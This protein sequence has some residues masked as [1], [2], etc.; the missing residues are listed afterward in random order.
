MPERFTLNNKTYDIPDDKIGIFMSK[1]PNAVKTK[2]K[3][4]FDDLAAKSTEFM[5][6]VPLA[7]PPT[8][9]AGGLVQAIGDALGQKAQEKI[10]DTLPAGTRGEG[11]RQGLGIAGRILFDPTSFI[12]LGAG[13]KAGGKLAKEIPNIIG[14]IFKTKSAAGFL[15]RSS[16]KKV[17]N[18]LAKLHELNK[19]TPLSGEYGMAIDAIKQASGKAKATHAGVLEEVARAGQQPF[20]VASKVEDPI[21]GIKQIRSGRPGQVHG[22]LFSPEEIAKKGF[23]W[24]KVENG[25]I[26]ESGRW[27][28][29]EEAA[30]RLGRTGKLDYGEQVVANKLAEIEAAKPLEKI[31][32]A[33]PIVKELTANQK[34]LKA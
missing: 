11:Y 27:M 17:D 4:F 23:K 15:A 30:T 31:A 32:G 10:L 16:A 12:P 20:S 33:K 8:M 26:D 21:T 24:D 18:V 9:R 19:T 7:G 6:M 14:D 22:D 2:P 34:L 3:S 1:Y 5:N 25:F 13:A 29:R 28:S